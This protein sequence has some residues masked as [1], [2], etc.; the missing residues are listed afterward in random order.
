MVDTALALLRRDLRDL[1]ACQV[2]YFSEHG[3]YAPSLQALDFV[4]APG[5]AL[6][7]EVGAQGFA[8]AG[9]C[10]GAPSLYGVRLGDGAGQ[11]TSR[12]EGEVFLVSVS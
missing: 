9:R 10:D 7:M 2:K 6:D 11:F 8:A 5:N 3:R 1:L 12:P 4:P